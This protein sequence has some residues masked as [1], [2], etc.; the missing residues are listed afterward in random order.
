MKFWL[1]GVNT[2]H[3]SVYF[4]NTETHRAHFQFSSA[5]G[6]PGGRRPVGSMRGEIVY[7]P[8]GT[9]PDG[10]RGTY[11]FEFQPNDAYSFAD[12]ALAFELLSS[13]MPFLTNN[14]SY[15]PMP[16]SATELY[17]LE[18]SLYDGYR[19]PVLTA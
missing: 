1:L 12:V 5:I 13:S 2:A 11:R 14:L 7:D 6:L 3:P 16:G 10:T 4:M 9:A 18:R 15:Y 19:V 8:N 17:G